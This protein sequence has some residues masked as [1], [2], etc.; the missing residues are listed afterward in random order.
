MR[1]IVPL[2]TQLRSYRSPVTKSSTGVLVPISSPDLTKFVDLYR[3]EPDRARVFVVSDAQVYRLPQL[4]HVRHFVVA[5]L[6]DHLRLYPMRLL[7]GLRCGL[8][9]RRLPLQRLEQ[10][11]HLPEPA[12]RKTTA[13]VP[14]IDQLAVIV[15]KAHQ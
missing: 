7:V 2:F 9:R 12:L 10:L 8:E 14:G 6:H 11:E 1:S 15:V 3:F 13:D 5:H 4:A